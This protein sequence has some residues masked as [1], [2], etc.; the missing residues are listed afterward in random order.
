MSDLMACSDCR[1][2]SKEGQRRRYRERQAERM[3]TDG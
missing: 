1:A 3:T 2:C